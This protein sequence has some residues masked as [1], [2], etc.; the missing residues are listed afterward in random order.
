MC[1]GAYYLGGCI[2]DNESNIDWMRERKLTWEKNIHTIS[3]TGGKYPQESYAAVVRAIQSEWIFIQR[4]TWDT[5]DEFA[6]VE[7]IIQ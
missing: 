5:G 7:K 1:T 6:G 2:G 3:E 4:V